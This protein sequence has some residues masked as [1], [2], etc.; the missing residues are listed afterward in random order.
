VVSEN[1]DDV[2]STIVL[3]ELPVTQKCAILYGLGLER[4]KFMFGCFLGNSCNYG[5]C[6]QLQAM[7]ANTCQ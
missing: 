3:K 4:W 1:C 6:L 7:S 5:Q 2:C